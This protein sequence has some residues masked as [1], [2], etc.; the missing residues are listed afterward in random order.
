MRTAGIVQAGTAAGKLIPQRKVG[1]SL[2]HKFIIVNLAM[3]VSVCAIGWQIRAQWFAAQAFRDAHLNVPLEL[4]AAPPVTSS[5]PPDAV[6]AAK[7]ADITRSD[8]FSKDRS[9]VAIVA[10]PVVEIPTPMPPLPVLSGVMCLPSGTRAIMAERVGAPSITV[11]AGEMLGEFKIVALDF[12]NITF[13]WRD[14]QVTRNIDDLIDRSGGQR[15]SSGGRQAPPQQI[16]GAAAP[17]PPLQIEAANTNP[18]LKDLGDEITTTMRSCMP[19]EA[20][21][22]GTLVEGYRKS[23]VSTPFGPVCRWRKDGNGT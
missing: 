13:A 12:Q 6:V 14:H 19:G 20:S 4:I 21:P 1:T 22:D 16:G 23:N 7:Y 17:T 15:L 8:L 2:K 5:A 3:G 9:G 10:P 18:M 11:R